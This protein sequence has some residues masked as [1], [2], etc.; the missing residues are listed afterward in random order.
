LI[1]QDFKDFSSLKRKPKAKPVE[2][3]TTQ[4][5]S[6][7]IKVE[8]IPKEENFQNEGK[9]LRMRGQRI[10]LRSLLTRRK[11]KK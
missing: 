2:P 8:N 7:D 10:Q 11:I 9:T 1:L 4:T 6:S 5:N 3:D